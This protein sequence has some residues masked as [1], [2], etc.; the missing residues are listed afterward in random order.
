VVVV[1]AIVAG[2]EV[3]DVEVVVVGGNVVVDVVV[4]WAWLVVVG[5]LEG[6]VVLEEE[7]VVV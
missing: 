1:P 2:K 5:R 6:V 3:D 4:V 7:G